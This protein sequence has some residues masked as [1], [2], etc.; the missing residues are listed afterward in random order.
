M[1]GQNVVEE[2]NNSREDGR[3]GCSH[4]CNNGTYRTVSGKG[5]HTLV[6]TVHTAQCQERVFTHL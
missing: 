1:K 4:T 3:E 6:T 2:K 5:V